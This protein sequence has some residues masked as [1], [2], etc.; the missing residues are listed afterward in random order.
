MPMSLSPTQRI[1][2]SKTL[3]RPSV[4][5]TTVL[6]EAMAITASSKPSVASSRRS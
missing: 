3:P 5:L 2:V 6:L 1:D 4:M